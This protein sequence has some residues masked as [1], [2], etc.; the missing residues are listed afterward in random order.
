MTER[1][2]T[3]L[4]E[5]LQ[6]RHPADTPLRFGRN[7]SL[8]PEDP[9]SFLDGNPIAQIEQAHVFAREDGFR[10]EETVVFQKGVGRR[11][12]KNPELTNPP[13]T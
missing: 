10:P 9:A 11:Y 7:G 2:N 4:A 13:M 12:I 5:I 3:V 6:G 1:M 8:G